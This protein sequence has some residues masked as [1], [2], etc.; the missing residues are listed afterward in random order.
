MDE[1]QFKGSWH[2][3]KGE[4]RKKWGQLTD[5]D[6]LECEDSY[7]KFLGVI[8]KDTATKR[9]KCSVGPMIGIQSGSSKK[10]LE[11]MPLFRGIKRKSFTTK[12]ISQRCRAPG[13]LAPRFA[14]A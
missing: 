1:N 12:T 2:Q 13:S 8:Q 6:L 7:E 5:D 14:G 9:T 4:L 11:D 3:F 10:S